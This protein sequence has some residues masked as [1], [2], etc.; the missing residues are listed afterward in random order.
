MTSKLDVLVVDDDSD[1]RALLVLL[2]EEHGLW[3]G[4]RGMGGRPTSWRSSFG[5]D[6][7]GAI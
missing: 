5:P 2:L 1:I 3:C 4:R 6:W 7:C